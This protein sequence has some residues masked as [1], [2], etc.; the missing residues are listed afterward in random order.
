MV[1]IN[2]HVENN[3]TMCR[4]HIVPAGDDTFAT[5]FRRLQDENAHTLKDRVLN[6]VFIVSDPNL[7]VSKVN[8]D[9]EISYFRSCW[10]NVHAL[11][12]VEVC[13]HTEITVFEKNNSETSKQ[14]ISSHEVILNAVTLPPTLVRPGTGNNYCTVCKEKML[15]KL[16][17]ENNGAF[18]QEDLNIMQQFLH[19]MSKFLFL[20]YGHKEMLRRKGWTTKPCWDDLVGDCRQSAQ[21]R[22][23]DSHHKLPFLK[24]EYLHDISNK[25]IACSQSHAYNSLIKTRFYSELRTLSQ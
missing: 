3:S 4:E 14:K 24:T 21:L 1:F 16:D 10:N 5:I 8:G 2:A 12:C 23:K 7:P 15:T 22:K 6:Q 25:L 20:L 18:V 17:H 11:A 9:L 13:I 19:H